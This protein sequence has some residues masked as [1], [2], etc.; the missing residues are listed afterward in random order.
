[1]AKRNT[2]P[3]SP[4]VLIAILG[5]A[6]LLIGA[7]GCGAGRSGET[8]GPQGRPPVPTAGGTGAGGAKTSAASSD[9]K[10]AIHGGPG[11]NDLKQIED[12][13]KTHPGGY[14]RY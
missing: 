3:H 8:V 2:C 9:A 14:T 7:A 5:A 10:Q 1:M 13:K 11:P 4:K 6:A 12:W